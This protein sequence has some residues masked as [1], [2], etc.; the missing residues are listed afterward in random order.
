MVGF[1]SES[2]LGLQ[3]ATLLLPSVFSK[4]FFLQLLTNSGSVGPTHE[5]RHFNSGPVLS[6]NS[7]SQR[8]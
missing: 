1:F 6:S 8:Y 5:P 2:L 3:V 4:N 7:H